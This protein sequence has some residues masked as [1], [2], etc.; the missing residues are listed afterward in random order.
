M[1]PHASALARRALAL[2]HSDG[3]QADDF[4]REAGPVDD[5]HDQVDVLVGIRL[6]LGQP[7]PRPAL[8]NHAAATQLVLDLST[9]PQASWLPRSGS[10][11]APC[12]GTGRA[13]VCSMLPG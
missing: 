12:R 5:V 4:L 3:P 6:L 7:L 9:V 1:G 8:H 2:D 10:T 13:E 11:A